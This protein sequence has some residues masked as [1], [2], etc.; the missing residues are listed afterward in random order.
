[1]HR[2]GPQAA[3][4][5][6]TK[7]CEVLASP[8]REAW[9]TLLDIET[10]MQNPQPAKLAAHMANDAVVDFAMSNT[11]LELLEGPVDESD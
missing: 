2:S 8:P 11:D 3:Q 5:S 1:M 6:A 10:A 7:I 9:R 4:I